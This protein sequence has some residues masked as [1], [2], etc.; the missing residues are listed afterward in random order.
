MALKSLFSFRPDIKLSIL[1]NWL[2]LENEKALVDFLGQRGIE[3]DDG[4]ESLDCRK[5]AN[6]KL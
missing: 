6:H 5:Y 3:V 1:T 2:Q 4:I